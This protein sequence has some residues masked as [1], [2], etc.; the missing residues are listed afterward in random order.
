MKVAVLV[1]YVVAFVLQLAGAYG[2]I[3]DVRTGIG[4]MRLFKSD[5]TDAEEAAHEHR[6]M[7]AEVRNK[8]RGYGLDAAMAK[9]TD[10]IGE[11][12]VEQTGRAPAVQRRALLKYVTAQND[13]STPRRWVPVWLLLV[14][15]LV[16]FVGNV[17][18][19]YI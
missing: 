9:L 12:A 1:L 18:S 6:Q 10:S 5:L 4:N 13:I 8:P 16:G 15:L 14:G 7:I 17:L 3:Q 19:L 11:A 2:V